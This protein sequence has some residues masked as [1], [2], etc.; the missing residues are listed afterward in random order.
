M[1]NS[2]NRTVTTSIRTLSAEERDIINNI[3]QFAERQN[4]LTTVLATEQNSYEEI[5]NHIQQLQY[6]LDHPEELVS[7]QELALLKEE[8][9]EISLKQQEIHR[10][11]EQVHLD[12]LQTINRINYIRKELVCYSLFKTHSITH[13]FTISLTHSFTL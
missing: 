4:Q 5:S 2:T 3:Q 9:N 8:F 6:Q 12:Q 13:S 1:K 11:Y 7:E 10:Q